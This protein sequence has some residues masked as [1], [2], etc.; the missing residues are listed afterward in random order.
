MFSTKLYPCTPLVSSC[1]GNNSDP[2]TI[3]Q[4]EYI[5]PLCQTCSS[6]FGKFG[7]GIC[8]PCYSKEFNCALIGLIVIIMGIIVLLIVK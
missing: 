3:C 1:T 6:D 4:K 8:L 7:S 5:G 2:A